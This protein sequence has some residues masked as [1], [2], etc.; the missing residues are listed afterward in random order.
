VS[1]ENERTNL[2]VDAISSLNF[3]ACSTH[4]RDIKY[5]KNFFS[6]S[7]EMRWETEVYEV[8]SRII[9]KFFRNRLRTILWRR[10]AKLRTEAGGQL[11]RTEY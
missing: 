11:L 10:F 5:T 2:S 1:I 7:D 4:M 3:Y 8:H 9:L 6:K